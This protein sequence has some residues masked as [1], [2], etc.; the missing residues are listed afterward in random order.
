MRISPS[1]LRSLLAYTSS[2]SILLRS[3][4]VCPCLAHS[5]TIASFTRV[6]LYAVTYVCT[7]SLPTGAV[8]RTDISRMPVSAILRVRGIGVA[9]K[10]STFILG[11]FSLSFSLWLTPKRCSSSRTSNPRSWNCTLSDKTLWVETTKCNVPSASRFK[12]S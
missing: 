6:S 3:M 2:P 5:L 7:G 11:Y 9:D 4:R 8:S 10:V 12:V 1:I